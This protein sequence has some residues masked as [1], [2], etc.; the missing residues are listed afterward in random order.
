M[1]I[2]LF[3]VNADPICAVTANCLN[4]PFSKLFSVRS[5]VILS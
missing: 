2:S 4:M 1:I 3:E 5:A